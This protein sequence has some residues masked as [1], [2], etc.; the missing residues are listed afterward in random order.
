MSDEKSVAAI[1]F[2][3]HAGKLWMMRF[4]AVGDAQPLLST[5]MLD[6]EVFRSGHP[7]EMTVAFLSGDVWHGPIAQG[8]KK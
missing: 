8:E 5:I 6:Q 4:E 7:I 2:K 1:T 3:D